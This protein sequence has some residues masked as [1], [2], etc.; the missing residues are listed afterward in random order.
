MRSSFILLFLLSLLSLRPS[1]S[2]N[3]PTDE[4]GKIVFVQVEKDSSRIDSLTAWTNQW[5]KERYTKFPIQQ[6]STKF[7][8]QGQFMVY[9]K[10]GVFMQPHGTIRYDFSIEFKENRYRY[11][12][13][14]F[15]FEYYKQERSDLKY[16]PTG[17]LKPLEDK[18]FK[19]YQKLW[20]KHKRSTQD[21]V[22]KMILSHKAFIANKK[23]PVFPLHPK[24]NDW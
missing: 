1:F 20:E 14:N 23:N 7:K 8:T 4:S 3:L 6:D 17:E 24:T 9:I 11:V 5:M 21:H 10:E 2:Q 22:K 15:I 19:G 12:F 18:E 13:S 16:H